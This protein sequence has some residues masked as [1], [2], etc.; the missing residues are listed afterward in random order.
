MEKHKTSFEDWFNSE[1]YYYDEGY[2]FN[3]D[4]YMVYYNRLIDL[5]W[6]KKSNHK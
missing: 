4:G 1:G 2:Y 3:K 6:G 5:Y